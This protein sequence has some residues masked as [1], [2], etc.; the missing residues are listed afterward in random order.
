M[1]FEGTGPVDGVITPTFNTCP[2][3]AFSPPHEASSGVTSKITAN[4][5]INNTNFLCF[6]FPPFSIFYPLIKPSVS[7]IVF[8]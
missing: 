6:I 3:W 4:T 7:F 2:G 1:P 5:I 8:T